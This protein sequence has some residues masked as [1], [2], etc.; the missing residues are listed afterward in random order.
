MTERGE[1][2]SSTLIVMVILSGI[3]I[4]GLAIGGLVQTQLAAQR[5]QTAAD[6]AALAAGPVS[7]F[8][9][10]PVDVASRLAAQ[11]DAILVD[12]ICRVDR[13]WSTRQVTTTA[14]ID[15][16]VV[17]FGQASVTRQAT[18]EFAPVKLLE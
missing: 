6:A 14:R 13:S 2:G 12:C 1:R 9:G 7:F 18:A 5:A 4:A 16:T 10:S 17:G 11:N 8:G 3:I 15:F